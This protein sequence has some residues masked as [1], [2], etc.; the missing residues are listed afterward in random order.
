MVFKNRNVQLGCMKNKLKQKTILV[1]CNLVVIASLFIVSCKPINP[2]SH[3]LISNNLVIDKVGQEIIFDKPFKPKKQVNKVCFDYFDK[4]KVLDISKPPVFPDETP[5][6]ITGYL[7]DKKGKRYDLDNISKNGTNY[8][9]LTPEY[10]SEWLNIYKK[11]ISFLKLY[12]SSNRKFNVSKI[13]WESY[14]AWDFK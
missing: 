14:N 13:E 1:L 12:V 3:T 5:L 2:F 6:L 9:C 4:L 10:T 8:L 11:D 7:V